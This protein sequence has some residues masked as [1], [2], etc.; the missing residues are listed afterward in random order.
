[1]LTPP[2]HNTLA[3]FKDVCNKKSTEMYH[4]EKKTTN[5]MKCG[6][7]F[8]IINV[9]FVLSFSSQYVLIRLIFL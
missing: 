5:K 6:N 3:G 1:M 4:P 9:A 8:I 7:Q 2:E